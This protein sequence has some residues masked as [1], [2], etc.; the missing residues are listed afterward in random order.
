MDADDE[1]VSG[2]RRRFAA[3]RSLAPTA[4]ATPRR[5]IPRSVQGAASLG[6]HDGALALLALTALGTVLVLGVGSSIDSDRGSPPAPSPTPW[7]VVLV[8]VPT[9]QPPSS[10][11]LFLCHDAGVEGL[12]R[13]RIGDARVVWI[14]N[15]GSRVDISWPPGFIARFAPELELLGPTGD[16]IAHDGD[17]VQLGGGYMADEPIFMACQIDG[18]VFP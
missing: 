5:V 12:L 3:I 16:V 18:R 10:G 11:Q 2:L 15:A 7:G 17:H 1:V 14:E 6:A 9:Y 13:G 8:S 4:A